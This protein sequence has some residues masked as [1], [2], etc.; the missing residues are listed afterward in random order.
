MIPLSSIFHPF[1]NLL[2]KICGFSTQIIRLIC[3]KP[4]QKKLI[5]YVGRKRESYHFNN[6]V[7]VVNLKSQ[8]YSNVILYQLSE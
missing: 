5:K 1:H 4:S 3:V 6:F 7:V 2:T 8:Q